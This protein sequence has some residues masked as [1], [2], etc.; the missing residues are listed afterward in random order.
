ML[1]SLDKRILQALEIDCRQSNANIAR[2]LRTN[3]TVINYRI[4]RLQK[5][6]I[7]T[8]FKCISNQ[9]ILGRMSFGLLIQFRDLSLKQEEELIKNISRIKQVSWT[10]LIN[11]KWDMIAVVMEKDIQSFN[12]VLQEIFSVCNNHIKDYNFYVDYSGSIFCHDYLYD[13]PKDC[14][15]KYAGGEIIKLKAVELAVYEA[16]RKNPRVSLLQI[17]TNLNR[18][19]DTIKSKFNYLKSK[20]ILLRC[21]PNINIRILGYQDN[22]CLLNLSPCQEKL[23][24]LLKFCAKDPYVLRYAQCLGHFQLI[25]S[26]HSKDSRQLKYTLSRIKKEF[27]DIINHYEIIQ[28]VEQS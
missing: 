20:K 5:R 17:A 26:I 3:K 9:L 11:S 7:I 28:T 10:A 22:L 1:D 8:G 19:Y 12:D 16:I 6:K 21:S 27:S 15:V 13:A 2:K 14:S 23:D 24:Q 4:G 25:L 18:T